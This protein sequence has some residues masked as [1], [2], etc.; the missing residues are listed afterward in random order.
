MQTNVYLSLEVWLQGVFVGFKGSQQSDS[1][2]GN[3]KVEQAFDRLDWKRRAKSEGAAEI[4]IRRY[5]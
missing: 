5:K 2:M 1:G 3:N 4:R